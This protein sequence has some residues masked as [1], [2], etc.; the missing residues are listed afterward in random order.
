MNPAFE[1]RRLILESVPVAAVLLFWAVLSW[2]GWEPVVAARVRD[3]GVVM[4]L[5]YAV[6]RGVKLGRRVPATSARTPGPS[7]VADV[8][9]ENA[10]VALAAGAWFLAALAVQFVEAAW[11]ATGLPG[12]LVSPADAF[13]FVLAGGG[14]GCVVVYAVA[15]GWARVRAGRTAG[16]GSVRE[17][18]GDAASADD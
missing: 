7:D 8:L 15:A 4:A 10:R 13:S 6:T 1:P 18:A 17:G 16:R 3:A 5:C 2:L 12:L 11:D 14:V 9:R